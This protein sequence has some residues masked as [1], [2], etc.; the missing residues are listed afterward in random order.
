MAAI[1]NG[2]TIRGVSPE[3]VMAWPIVVGIFDAAGYNPVLTSVTGGRHGRGTLH[4]HGYAMD[5]RTRHIPSMEEKR[6]IANA[7]KIRL[8]EEFDVVFHDGSQP[9]VAEHIHI[10]YDHRP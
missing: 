4:H 1:K 9:G 10:E 8:G 3:I 7:L 5:I 2:V 6:K